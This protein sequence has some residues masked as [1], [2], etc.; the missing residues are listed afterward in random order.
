M[1][2]VAVNAK[3]AHQAAFEKS[4]TPSRPRHERPN[5]GPRLVVDPIVHLQRTIGNQAVLRLMQGVPALQTKL[6]VNQPGNSYEKE[7]DRVAEQVMRTPAPGHAFTPVPL[8]ISRMCAECEEEEEGESRQREQAL[9][10]TRQRSCTKS[11]DRRANSSRPRRERISNRASGV[12]S[13][14]CAYTPMLTRQIGK[15][16]EC[17]GLHVGTARGLC[18]RS[19]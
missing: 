4:A 13:A 7:A 15:S 16:P 3:T 2:A 6:R 17:L 19:I 10:A 5:L 12:I 11:C 9:P 8:Q 1:R 14:E 18:D